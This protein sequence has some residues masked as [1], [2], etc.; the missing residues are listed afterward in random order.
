MDWRLYH[1]IYDVSLHHHWVGSL[2]NAIE[3]A[4][5]PFMVV[6]TVALWLLARPGGDRKWKLAAGSGLGAAAVALVSNQVIHAIWDRPRPYEAHQISHPWSSSTDAS[7]PSDHASAS[8]AIAFAVLAFDPVVGVLFVVAALL[9]AVGRVLIG[10]HYPADVG[11]SLL[12][13]AGSAL[14]VVRFGRPVIAFLVRVVERAT[15]PVLR[16]LWRRGS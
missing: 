14:L 11:A 3:K 4:S 13:A 15:D 6:V 2:F 5:I 7:F 10:A 12:V 1:A 9:I 8:L 16:P